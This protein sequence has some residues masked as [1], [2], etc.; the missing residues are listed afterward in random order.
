MPYDDGTIPFIVASITPFPEVVRLLNDAHTSDIVLDFQ[1]CI[2]DLG[3]VKD[4]I[5][6][7]GMPSQCRTIV[8]SDGS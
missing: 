6:K 1:G 5:R 3:S 2:A 4:V 8:V 7:D